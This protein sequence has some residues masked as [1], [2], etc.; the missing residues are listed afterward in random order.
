MTGSS[1]SVIAAD[2]G[3]TNGRFTLATFVDGNTMPVLSDPITYNCADHSG[4]GDMLS[5]Y[6]SSIGDRAPKVAK[7]AV[8]GPVTDQKMVLTN[9]GW[10]VDASALQ[11]DLGLDSVLLMN[12]FAALAN[13]TLYL[14]EEDILPLIPDLEGDV[15]SPVSIIG[16]GTGFGVALAV[17]RLVDRDGRNNSPKS[18]RV[19]ATEGGHMSFSPRTPLERD[20]HAHLSDQLGHVAVEHL[21]SG[22]GLQR[23][24]RYLVQ[25]G[26]SGDAD[27][28][29]AQITQA[30]EE[31][32]APSCTRAVQLFLS[33]L[34]SVAGDIALTH[35]AR[36][37]VNIGGGILPKM[38]NLIP[39]SDLVSRFRD[40]GI[41]ADYLQDI[42][43]NVILAGTTA[44]M[45]A[46]L[47]QG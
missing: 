21:L 41:M 30:A 25:Y 6:M 14:D 36:G 40:K 37:G 44:Q 39:Q 4:V 32:N 16:P 3:G 27:L 8:A 2:I 46:A 24:H 42:P 11:A 9:L 33:I 23:I 13:A 28:E 18:W 22:S 20:L 47:M 1:H 35:G 12:D 29:P 34:G 10:N 43:V 7:L 45:G 31:G 17:P 15:L 26:G 19:V 5:K 38:R